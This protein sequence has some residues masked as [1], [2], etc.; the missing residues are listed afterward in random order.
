[1]NKIAKLFM[2]SLVSFSL[3]VGNSASVDFKNEEDFVKVSPKTLQRLLG[4]LESIDRNRS[5]EPWYLD[6][7]KG[8]A[9][10][11]V[12]IAVVQIMFVSIN[13][14]TEK[15][16]AYKAAKK[17]K[18][19]SQEDG[20]FKLL[21]GTIPQEVKDIVEYIKDPS[22]LEQFGI[23]MPKGLLLVGPPGNGKTAYARA[24]A[25]EAGA[26]FF[27]ASATQFV[28][29]YVGQGPAAVRA[30][31]DRA[32]QSIASGAYKKSIIFIDEID[33]IG[34]K[35]GEVGDAGGGAQE[36][37]NTLNE[38]LNQ[39]DGFNQD[40]NIIVIAA[41]N[42]VA[43]LDKALVRPGRF[44][45][46]IQINNP[47]YESRIAI[48]KFYAQNKNHSLKKADFETLARNSEG[49]SAA[50]IKNFVNE[51][52]VWAMR[53]KAT[54]MTY[55]HFAKGLESMIQTKLLTYGIA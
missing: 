37:R 50:E 41:T 30:L 2:T 32:R 43:H 49:L 8:A 55:A 44:D 54:T 25:F 46:V 13:T 9:R 24:I 29:T 26:S 52:A 45:R 14:I 16:N 47:D 17:L 38:L 27:D 7:L 19:A 35:R 31:F 42:T 39:M 33:A 48:I 1:M 28:Q 11:A 3:I 12:T 34:G 20:G 6:T 23:D 4:A 22:L 5:A 21:A 51:A 40:S 36:Y 18:D 10:I 15:I 53:E